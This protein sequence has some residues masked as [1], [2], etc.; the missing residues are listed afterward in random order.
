MSGPS[1]PSISMGRCSFEA[2]TR[3]ANRKL[4]TLFKQDRAIQS[5]N[6]ISYLAPKPS[7]H[8]AA[9]RRTPAGSHISR[10]LSLSAL[11]LQ[12][13]GRP[14]TGARIETAAPEI[15]DEWQYR[16]PLT[17][18]RIETAAMSLRS[19]SSRSPP[20]RGA[21]RNSARRL[22]SGQL[23]TV[24]P[25]QGRGSK[26]PPGL[27]RSSRRG[28]VAPSQGRGSKQRELQGGAVEA[29]SPPHR[30]AD[31]NS[32]SVRAGICS[33]CR[34]LTGARIETLNCPLA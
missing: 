34:P 25:S 11:V 21:D 31:R 33:P 4:P 29:R 2:L 15:P 17:G 3:R 9:R 24:A 8:C 22:L 13:G 27:R 18:A 14:L 30:G 23:C 7:A 10:V 19:W 28:G 16:R 12:P 1:R 6:V 20:H 26:P 5:S 32:S